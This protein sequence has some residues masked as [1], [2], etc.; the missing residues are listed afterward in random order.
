MTPEESDA[1]LGNV[2]LADL[3]AWEADFEAWAHE[4][5]LEPEGE[6][7]RT[8]LMLAGRG[9]GKTRAGAEWVARLA[10]SRPCRIALVAATID[11]ARA[12]MV[13]GESGLLAVLKRRKRTRWFWEPS[14]RQLRFS[15]GSVVMLYSG[16]NPDGLRGGHHHHAWCDELAKWAKPQETW[17]N[18][19]MS[20][21]AGMRP[22]ALVTTT[23]RPLPMLKRLG[24]DPLTVTT[25]GRT[26]DNLVLEDRFLAAMQANYAGTRLGRQELDGELIEDVEGALWTRAGLETCRVVPRYAVSTGS[27]ATRD[28]RESYR[29]VVVAVDPPA[30]E[31]GD[32]CGI[33]VAALGADGLAYV[34]E[35]ATA[36]GLS[37]QGWA[38]RVS[39]TARRHNA[40]CVVVETNMGGNLVTAIMRQV[41]RALPIRTVHASRGKSARAEP[42]ALLY[43]RG[44]VR[45]RR[46][47]PELED[48]MCGMLAG[49]GYQGPGRSPDRADA[50]VWA[51]TELM[52]GARGE[53]RVRVI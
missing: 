1:W 8:W 40:D 36:S 25:R 11:E 29:R 12:V 43:E 39:E 9:Y 46:A 53:A 48:Q 27:T 31:G 32:A 41:D 17:D 35:D 4:G 50:L 26:V 14:L 49:G 52:L 24:A 28:E 38:G 37:P 42:V 3:K 30:S 5:Q 21:R 18:L 2:T 51:L 45:H 20:L 10:T 47:F 44:L 6:D 23:P 34:L 16:E 22:R 13:E 7:W 19:Q 15:N 33:M